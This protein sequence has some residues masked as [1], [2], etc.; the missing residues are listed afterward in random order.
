MDILMILM[1]VFCPLGL[2]LCAA[3]AFLGRFPVSY[4][5]CIAY[6]LT[7]C[8]MFLLDT[9]YTWMLV[10]T[11]VFLLLSCIPKMRGRGR[12]DT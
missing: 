6:V 7:I 9:G 8:F 4:L 3:G 1:W 12:K 2:I 11:L 10:V 5:G